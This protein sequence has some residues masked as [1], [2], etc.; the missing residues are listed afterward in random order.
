MRPV[1]VGRPWKK[2]VRPSMSKQSRPLNTS[3]TIL[4]VIY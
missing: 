2:A 4:F 1:G 3:H